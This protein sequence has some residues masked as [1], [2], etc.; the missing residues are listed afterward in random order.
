MHL[1][2][3]HNAHAYVCIRMRWLF[4]PADINYAH[5]WKNARKSFINHISLLNHMHA[6][7]LAKTKKRPADLELRIFNALRIT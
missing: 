4:K 6:R 1:S 2:I 5:N 3:V 7:V